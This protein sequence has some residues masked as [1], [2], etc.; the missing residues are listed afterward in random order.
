MRLN[1]GL[2]IGGAGYP[3]TTQTDTPPNPGADLRLAVRGGVDLIGRLLTRGEWLVVRQWLDLPIPAQALYARL[4]GR[5]DRM[6]PIV[7]LGDEY[8]EVPH[9]ADALASLTRAGF[10]WTTPTDPLPAH[11]RLP[12]YDRTALAR[13]CKRLG[14][15][16]RGKRNALEA[17]ILAVGPSALSHLNRP[18]V[19]LRHRGL[20]RRLCRAFLGRSGGDLRAM[21]LQRMGVIRFAEYTPTG[22]SGPFPD[23]RTMVALEEARRFALRA[24]STDALDPTDVD[25]ALSLVRHAQ[26]VPPVYRRHRAARFGA[27]VAEAAAAGLERR[28]RTEQAIPIWAALAE[29][30]L[31]I[32]TTA[33]R[34]LAICHDRAGRPELGVRICAEA[35]AR[36][37]AESRLAN[38]R[39][40]RRLARKARLPWRPLPRLM[41]PSRRTLTLAQSGHDGAR[42]QWSGDVVETATAEAVR[43]QGR[44][45]VEGENLL[46]T[47]LFGLLL[48]DIL[49]APVPGMLPGRM[50]M[51]PLD[52]GL[53]DFASRRK[54][55]LHHALE[56]IRADHGRGRLHDAFT[57]HHGTAIRGVSW[58]RWSQSELDTILMGLTGAVVAGV[59]ER[60][61]QGASRSG[62]PDL[63]IL[64]GPP[65]RIDGLFPG[66]LRGGPM[67]VEVKGPGDSLRDNQ[68]VWLHHLIQLGVTTEVWDIRPPTS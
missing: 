16:H 14:L 9:P 12:L 10:V 25:H 44:G 53:P 55:P 33:A 5:R 34:R 29:S 67:A 18:G 30:P 63:W 56:E 21:V 31:L 61:A 45:V 13:L 15:D 20:F 23:R 19:R 60:L 11:W 54:D 68:R 52:L 50:Q 59:L 1:I 62:L 39:T 37:T 49:F 41:E 35:R 2:R 48:R 57:N 28:G 65:V 51:A 46:W 8:N 58:S 32:A 26:S 43:V 22:G 36:G 4:F 17:R 40:G 66:R 27:L 24:L 6:V 42:P 3:M 38:E 47:T 64:C 7:G